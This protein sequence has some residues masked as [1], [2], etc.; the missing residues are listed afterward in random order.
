MVGTSRENDGGCL[1]SS[2]V[3]ASLCLVQSGERDVRWASGEKDVRSRV[4]RGGCVCAQ[5]SS[6]RDTS[7][8]GAALHNDQPGFQSSQGS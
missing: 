3:M 1:C 6:L 7:G 2:D 5:G 4:E 8:S